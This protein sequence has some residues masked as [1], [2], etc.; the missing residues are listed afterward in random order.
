MLIGVVSLNYITVDVHPSE[1]GT[2]GKGW[3]TA[4]LRPVPIATVKLA[5]PQ[6]FS[7]ERYIQRL[8]PS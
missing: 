4:E 1:I 6:D 5:S 7:P 2:R 3:G 8:I